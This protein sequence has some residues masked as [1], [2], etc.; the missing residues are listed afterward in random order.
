MRPDIGAGG[1]INGAGLVAGRVCL[2]VPRARQ[3]AQHAISRGSYRNGGKDAECCVLPGTRRHEGEW[4]TNI[5]EPCGHRFPGDLTGLGRSCEQGRWLRHQRADSASEIHCGA[6]K[7]NNVLH[8]LFACRAKW[9]W[10]IPH[11]GATTG[12]NP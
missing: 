5:S 8:G 6:A 7:S 10:A 4:L 3:L 1:A 2:S 11:A 12:E 9:H